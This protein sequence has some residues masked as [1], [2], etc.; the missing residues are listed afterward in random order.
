MKDRF[1]ELRKE[2]NVT[3]QEFADKL[4]ISRNFVAQIEMGSKVPSDRTIDDVCREFNVNEE[5][6]R[7]GNGDMF[8]PGIKDK[9]ISAMLADVMK[10][11]EDSF[12]HRLVSALARLDDEGWDNLEKLIDMISN[13]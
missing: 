10:S 2:L 11:G 7:T 6:L 13:K 8:V 5:W 3:Q 1:K 12:R 9:Q 4:K